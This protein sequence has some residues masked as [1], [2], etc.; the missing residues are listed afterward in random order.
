M[1]I[2][3]KKQ[4]PETHSVEKEKAG[5]INMEYHPQKNKQQHKEKEPMEA[6]SYKETK[7][8]MAIENSHM[9]VITLY[10]NGLNSPIKHRVADWSKNQNQP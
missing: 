4:K 6:Q 9:S 8:K 2:T 3:R 5:E 10:V 7:D 1:V